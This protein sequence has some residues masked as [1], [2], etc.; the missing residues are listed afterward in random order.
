MAMWEG[1]KGKLLEEVLGERDIITDSDQG[2]SFRAF[3]RVLAF[4]P[5]PGGAFWTLG[6]CDGVARR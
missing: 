2:R 5:P 4:H 6:L 3:W 1:G